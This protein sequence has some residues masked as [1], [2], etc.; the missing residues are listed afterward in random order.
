[1]V[2]GADAAGVSFS[3]TTN[4]SG[5]VTLAGK[6]GTWSFTA[7]KS[8]YPSKTWTQS[9]SA[10]STVHAF[11]GTPPPPSISAAL[12]QRLLDLIDQYAESYYRDGWNL[13]RTQFKAW[14]ATIA[15]AEGGRGGYT[16]HSQYALGSDVFN[17]VAIGTAFRFSTGIGPFQLDVGNSDPTSPYAWMYWPTIQKLDPDRSVES[18]VRYHSENYGTVTMLLDFAANSPWLGTARAAEHWDA[19]TGTD[20]N[21]YSS[22]KAELDWPNIRL[23][24]AQNA[25]DPSFRYESN[26]Q[27]LG[28]LRWHIPESWGLKTDA[29]A[30]VVFDGLF[31][32][33]LVT[34]R[35]DKG[36]EQYRYYYA[37]REDRKIEVWVY[38]PVDAVDRSFRYVF[39][40]EYGRWRFPEHRSGTVAGEQALPSAALQPVLGD[41]NGDCRVSILD[42]ILVRNLLGQSPT[43]GDNWRADVNGDWKIN[44]LDLMLVLRRQGGR[45][46]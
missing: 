34:A 39:V 40:R 46:P 5:Y 43:T 41:V 17:H 12:D 32:T 21:V 4:S 44:I 35:N 29:L 13:S 28:L 31:P 14:I 37:Y 22:I 7:S 11:V 10:D 18:V 45:C 9:I 25:A 6:P 15:S 33:W 20:W 30:P 38:S 19:V 27:D 16:A 42:M 1:L 3:A 2:T 23:R 36:L 8:G 26:V 24:L